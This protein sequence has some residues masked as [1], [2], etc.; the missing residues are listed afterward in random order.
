VTKVTSSE[1]AAG[2]DGLKR[3]RVAFAEGE[4]RLDHAEHDRADEGHREIGGD[5]AQSAG[6]RHGVA[7]W[8][9]LSGASASWLTECMF[10]KKSAVLPRRR[11]ARWLSRLKKPEIKTLKSL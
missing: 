8:P 1:A 2:T 5:H 6:E 10:A 7:P 9:A 3:K 11:G 4:G